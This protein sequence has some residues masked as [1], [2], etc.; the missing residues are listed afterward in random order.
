MR[1]GRPGSTATGTHRHCVNSPCLFLVACSLF[2]SP[3]GCGGRRNEEQRNKEQGTRNKRRLAARAWLATRWLPRPL[4]PNLRI[5]RRWSTVLL[6]LAGLCL[7]ATAGGQT[8]PAPTPLG[9]VALDR[10]V[11]RWHAPETGGPAKPQFVFERELAFE[12]RL[13]ALA[14]PDADGAVFRERH[15]RAAL[16]RHVAETLLASLPVIPPAK[17][18]EVAARAELARG[19]LEQRVRGRARLVAAA[20]AE[21]IGSDELDAMLRR[22][23]RASI[24][25]D[26][27]IAPMLEPSEL[28]LRELF[29]SGGAA[30]GGQNFDAALPVLRRQYL[31]R[32]MEQAI[33]AHYQ[34]ARSRVTMIVVRAKR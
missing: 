34:N 19:M 2:P 14:D 23:A 3:F 31:S 13:E 18:A 21:G 5:M 30:R 28:E 17:P 25:L 4:R 1:S 33:T 10:V 27:M 26:K 11:L 32:K 12:A 29:D 8:S 22:Q 9:A 16:D 24:Y 6:A 7:S 15:I 20:V